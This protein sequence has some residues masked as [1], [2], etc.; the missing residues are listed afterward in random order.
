MMVDYDETGPFPED[1]AMESSQPNGRDPNSPEPQ[2]SPLAS[3][4]PAEQA[5]GTE[6]AAKV[7]IPT[8]NEAISPQIDAGLHRGFRPACGSGGKP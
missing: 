6:D 2:F 5:E 8:S 3:S 1:T 7:E 4:E